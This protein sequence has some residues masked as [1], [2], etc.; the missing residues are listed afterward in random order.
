MDFWD[1]EILEGIG[2]SILIF[3][4]VV[5]ST[6]KGRYMSY[7]LIY[8]YMNIMEPFPDYIELEYYDEIWQQPIDYENI[9]FRCR[10]CHEYGHLYQA[11]SLNQKENPPMDERAWEMMAKED[12]EG[13]QEVKRRKRSQRQIGNH[14]ESQNEKEKRTLNH[15]FV[16][17]ED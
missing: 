16:L 6:R 7:A 3:V 17:Q 9:H 1:P 14:R 15:F 11:C 2:N 12:G 5:D 10:R 13:F 8:V 4:K